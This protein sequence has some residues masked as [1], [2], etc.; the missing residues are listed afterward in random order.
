MAR[1]RTKKLPA[2]PEADTGRNSRASF[3]RE[4]KG[5]L[6]DS[7]PHGDG[8]KLDVILRTAAQCFSE[9]GF[10]ATSLDEISKRVGL[11]KA[12][13]YHYVRSKDDI[14]Y[15]CLVR[16]FRDYSSALA[17]IEDQTIP[18]LERLRFFFRNF[19]Y[20]QN[21]LF[22]RCVSAVGVEA[23]GHEPGSRIR[24]FRRHL[25]HTVRALLE[26]GIA[27]GEIRPCPVPVASAA[28]FGA[29]TWISRWHQPGKGISLEQVCE[30]FLRIFI[31][32][33]AAKPGSWSPARR[34]SQPRKHA[35]AAANANEP[36]GKLTEILLAAAQCFTEQ[37]YESAS[38]VD[39]AEKVH[40]HKA[41]LYHYIKSKNELLLKCLE[42]SF[43]D[44][45]EL[46]VYVKNTK[47]S[48]IE[49]LEY[50]FRKLVLAQNS[51]FGRCMNLISP[52]PVDDE[53]GAKIR[54]FQ[55]R[56]DRIARDLIQA[57]IDTGELK[58]THPVIAAAFLFGSTNWIPHW[59]KPGR[60][61]GLE[62][63]SDE[64]LRIFYCGIRSRRQ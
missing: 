46:A 60:N 6:E 11:H 36:H 17:H 22:G 8:E 18:C 59:F 24:K 50:F 14:L 28:I 27:K 19:I 7:L 53:S 44:L 25:D 42:R 48:P 33:L 56:L 43:S 40:L 57:G 37:G 54:E 21:N 15:S 38:L 35:Q 32:G 2:P 3:A 26:E 10:A 20:A 23:L 9:K 31:D 51:D 63:I 30:E 39:I 47:I 5:L 61:L 64:F 55:R 58:P 34:Q 41:T 16:S 49:R 45:N 13:L 12:T 29:F 1:A 62:A 52:Q 4:W